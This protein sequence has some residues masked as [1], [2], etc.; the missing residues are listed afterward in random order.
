MISKWEAECLLHS[1][2]LER[3]I[4]EAVSHKYNHATGKKLFI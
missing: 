3:L 2:K 1:E 4:L